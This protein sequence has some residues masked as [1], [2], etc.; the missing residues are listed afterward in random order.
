MKRMLCLLLCATFVLTLAGCNPT[1]A[2]SCRELTM[3]VP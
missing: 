3:Q 1:K 2:Y